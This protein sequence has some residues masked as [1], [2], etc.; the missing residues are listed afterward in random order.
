MSSNNAIKC[1]FGLRNRCR[2]IELIVTTSS[3]VSL[4]PYG[5]IDFVKNYCAT[6]IKSFY[7]RAKMK[8]SKEMIVVNTL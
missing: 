5:S 2:V 7:A 8:K 6:C 3:N 1:L 4:P